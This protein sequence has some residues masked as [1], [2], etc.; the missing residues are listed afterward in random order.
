MS[1][2]MNG[3][4]LAHCIQNLPASLGR[5][6]EVSDSS[7]A[8]MASLSKQCGTLKSER[9]CVRGRGAR[10]VGRACVEQPMATDGYT[11]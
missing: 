4:T 11:Y 1:W 3:D 7:T 8:S 9:G 10:L 5:P 2:M 6:L